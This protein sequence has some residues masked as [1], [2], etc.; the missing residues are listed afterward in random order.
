MRN[1]ASTFP[2]DSWDL[3]A[4]TLVGV[5]F[6]PD[7]DLAR[8]RLATGGAGVTTAGMWPNPVLGL[9]MERVTNVLPGLTPWTYGFDFTV[10]L[11]T[12]WKR[13]YRMTEAE[14]LRE[15]A[16]LGLTDTGWHVRSRI[17][18]ALADH[19]FAARELELRVL[20]EGA[21]G[22]AATALK[23][24]LA[25]GE[26]FRLDV[27]QADGEV[28]TAR[29]AI[30]IAEGKV[31]ETRSA[32]AGALGIPPSALQGK[33]L[34]WPELETPPTLESLH[35]A[36]QRVAGILSRL[37]L[38]GLLAEYQAAEAALAREV[39]SR[40][41]DVTVGPGYLYDQ[42]QRKF[43]LGAN[44]TLPIFNQN[45][46]PIAEALARRTEIAA[47]FH[48]L[49]ATAIGDQESAAERYR[50][51]LAE[52]DESDRSLETIDRRE[53]ATRRAVELGDLEKTALI[54]LRLESVQAQE[55]KIGALRRVEEA[56]GSLEDAFERPLGSRRGPPEPGATNP[57]KE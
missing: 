57:R 10:A 34:V 9:R 12:L 45:D 55:L 7:L 39:A 18:A 38:V 25:L 44:V 36:D 13:G 22:E 51:A 41:P 4:L 17:R 42:G 40:Y 43:V 52:R 28:Y 19:L 30:R 3:G 1:G 47:R 46:G 21:R 20:E 33:T 27:D 8:A 26:I 50:S 29:S 15:A 56:L 31:V 5:Y 14:Q 48:A 23:R 53:K 49:Q 16:R 54:G 32:L 6:S 2:P 11:D 24:K 35:L 37:D